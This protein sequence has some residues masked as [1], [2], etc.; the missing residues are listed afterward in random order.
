MFA[1][2]SYRPTYSGPI[3]ATGETMRRA[4]NDAVA[5]GVSNANRRAV[6]PQMSGVRAGTGMQNY[7]TNVLQGLGELDAR[8]AGQQA[9]N[10]YAQQNAAA[11]LQYQA[12]LAS[13]M[14]GLRDL[15]F[16][17]DS[18]DMQYGL[19]MEELAADRL[20]NERQ[21]AAGL[22]VGR[23]RLDA[24]N[25]SIISGLLGSS[26]AVLDPRRLAQAGYMSP[27]FYHMNFDRLNQYS[28]PQPSGMTFGRYPQA[29]R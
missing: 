10:N 7:R 13:E 28:R 18:E 29:Y 26:N 14:S 4:R 2:Q 3:T 22:S 6:R 16:S 11:G 23:A 1:P 5:T 20:L 9:Y 21:R 8:M 15:L 24:G 27:D 17:R 19:G 25:A 12:N